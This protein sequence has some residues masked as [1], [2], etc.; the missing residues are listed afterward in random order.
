MPG[1]KLPD[2]P[3]SDDSKIPF[4]LLSIEDPTLYSSAGGGALRK[5]SG[6]K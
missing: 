4:R 1:P 5:T 2:F 3:I 6:R